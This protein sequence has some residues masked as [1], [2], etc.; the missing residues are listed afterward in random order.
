[1]CTSLD[2]DFNVWKGLAPFAQELIQEEA[3]EIWEQLLKEV[4]T[5]GGLLLN[6]PRRLDST[7][8]KLESGKIAVRT[9][10]LERRLGR[11]EQSNRKLVGAV[12]FAALLLGGIQLSLA[13]TAIPG[14]VLLTVSALTLGWILFSSKSS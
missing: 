3:G 1:M 11:L 14:Y 10:E 9:P 5:W 4:T 8:T 12:I 7:L 6:L 2:P 13:G